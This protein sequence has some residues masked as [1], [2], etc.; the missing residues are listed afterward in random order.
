MN[1][2]EEL[3]VGGKTYTVNKTNNLKLGEYNCSGEIDYKEL[4]IRILPTATGRMEAS[5][6]HE[7]VH[8]IYD[9][10]GYKEHDEKEVDEL[11]NALHMVMQDNPQ[12]FE[13]K[14]EELNN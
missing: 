2:P 12:V 8:A 6:I 13:Q 3:K 14:R 4:E 1:I 9:H 11:A 5:F 7:M 10:L